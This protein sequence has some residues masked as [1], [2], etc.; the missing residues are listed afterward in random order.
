MRKLFN[1][2]DPETVF[3]EYVQSLMKNGNKFMIFADNLQVIVDEECDEWNRI[4]GLTYPIDR[5]IAHHFTDRNG[6]SGYVMTTNCGIT[7]ITIPDDVIQKL[8]EEFK[9]IVWSNLKL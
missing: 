7:N 1:M 4:H 2:F 5:I 9:R 3:T 8:Y 6:I